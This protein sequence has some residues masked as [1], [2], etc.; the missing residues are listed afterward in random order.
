MNSN[1]MSADDLPPP[2]NE[3]IDVVDPLLQHIAS[4]AELSGS[5]LDNILV[6]IRERAVKGIETYGCT[7]HTHNGRPEWVDLWQELLDA[8]QYAY[9]ARLEGR[10]E[11]PAHITAA[12]RV[13][14]QILEAP[15]I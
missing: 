3:G 9:Q 4:H 12:L 7:L 2:K 10:D 11:I 14:T 1:L 5:Q 13:L 15:S 8:I 6:G